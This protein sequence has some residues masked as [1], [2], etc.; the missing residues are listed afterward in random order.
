MYIHLWCFAVGLS[1]DASSPSHPRRTAGT[2]S[3]R[4][5][6]HTPPGWTPEIVRVRLSYWRF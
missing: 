6:D 1:A 5:S 2:T 4:G 3:A